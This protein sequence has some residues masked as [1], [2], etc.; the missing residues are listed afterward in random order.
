[1]MN[2]SLIQNELLPEEVSYISKPHIK[3]LFTNHC[4]IKSS[5]TIPKSNIMDN[6]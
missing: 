3:K 2:D 4:S 1:M 5:D 6:L